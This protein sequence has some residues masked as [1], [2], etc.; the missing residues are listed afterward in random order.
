M[1]T[2]PAS[3]LLAIMEGSGFPV[4]NTIYSV[5]D[6]APPAPVNLVATTTISTRLSR[7]P[8]PPRC[9]QD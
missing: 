7:P 2:R 4:V 1:A 8:D 6:N 9:S 5:T 3:K